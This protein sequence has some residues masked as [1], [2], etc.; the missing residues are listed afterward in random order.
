MNVPRKPIP[1]TAEFVAL[2]RRY[3]VA[4]CWATCEPD[5]LSREKDTRAFLRLPPGDDP[6]AYHWPVSGREV[7]LIGTGVSDRRILATCRALLRNDA[8]KIT[9][10]HGENWRTP[11]LTIVSAK[12]VRHAA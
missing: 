1:G 12:A 11:H 2:H 10:I 3:P 8:L 4:T 9:I 5:A 7:V 6:A